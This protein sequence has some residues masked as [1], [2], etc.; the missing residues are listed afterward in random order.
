[1]ATQARVV[2]FLFEPV[3]SVRALLVARRDVTRD[4][5]AEGF[6]LGA[7]EDDEIA[8][9]SG[10]LFLFFLGFCGAFFF[11]AVAA[12]FKHLFVVTQRL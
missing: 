3:R 8:G 4:G 10:G 12:F 9:H 11:V 6:R 7:F 2:L 5:F 1:M